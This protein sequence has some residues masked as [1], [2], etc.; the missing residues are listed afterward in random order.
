MSFTREQALKILQAYDCK[1]WFGQ[2]IWVRFPEPLSSMDQIDLFLVNIRKESP[3]IQLA[4]IAALYRERKNPV[5]N[6]AFCS[7]L[8]QQETAF[9]ARLVRHFFREVE[10]QNAA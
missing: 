1:K 6:Q 5:A 9:P 7:L 8:E 10:R 3:E 2:M 4:H